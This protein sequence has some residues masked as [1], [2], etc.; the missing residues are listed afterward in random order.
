MQIMLQAY[1]LRGYKR[2]THMRLPLRAYAVDTK[3]VSA[4][5]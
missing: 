1:A 2:V 5:T 4:I 3:S